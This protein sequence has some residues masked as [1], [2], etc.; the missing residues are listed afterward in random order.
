MTPVELL[1]FGPGRGA[2]RLVDC[3]IMVRVELFEAF[4]ALLLPEF[5][6]LGLF[7]G[8]EHTVVVFVEAFENALFEFAFL[9]LW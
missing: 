3:S 6:S 7:L 2:F 5:L 4:R 8:I 9:R 1:Q